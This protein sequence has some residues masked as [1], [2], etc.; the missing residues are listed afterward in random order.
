[1]SQKNEPVSTSPFSHEMLPK[2]RTAVR[3]IKKAVKH[4]HDIFLKE[5]IIGAH[6]CIW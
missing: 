6:Q 1:M 2:C 5:V 3:K 4:A